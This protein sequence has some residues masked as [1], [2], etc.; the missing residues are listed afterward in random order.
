MNEAFPRFR[1]VNRAV[2]DDV[3]GT[4]F[5]VGDML[6]DAPGEQIYKLSSTYVKETWVPPFSGVPANMVAFGGRLYVAGNLT[7]ATAEFFNFGYVD[8]ATNTLQIL[9][10][11]LGNNS[12]IDQLSLSGGKII[13]TQWTVAGNQVSVGT[14]DASG[15][16]FTQFGT[17]NAQFSPWILGADIYW[18]SAGSWDAFSGLYNYTINKSQ[19]ASRL[20]QVE[21]SF[22]ADSINDIKMDAESFYIAGP[23]IDVGGSQRNN[24]AVVSRSGGFVH[25]LNIVEGGPAQK[26]F[27][28]ADEVLIAGDFTGVQG[29]AVTNFAL[30]NRLDLSLNPARMDLAGYQTSGGYY[31]YGS[32]LELAQSILIPSFSIS[33]GTKSAPGMFA[34]N[35]TTNSMEWSQTEVPYNISSNRSSMQ[36]DNGSLY[37]FNTANELVSL[38]PSG[39]RTTTNFNINSGVYSFFI[40]DQKLFIAGGFTSVLGQPVQGWAAIDLLT[41]QLI[42][43][44][45]PNL[46]D[47]Y[48]AVFIEQGGDLYLTSHYYYAND[49]N[50]AIY[51]WYNNDWLLLSLSTASVSSLSR[52]HFHDNKVVLFGQAVEN[53]IV[54]QNLLLYN[55]ANKSLSKEIT[56]SSK[57]YYVPDVSRQASF[58][59]TSPTTSGYKYYVYDPVNEIINDLFAGTILTNYYSRSAYL[60]SVLYLEGS[61]SAMCLSKIE[62]GTRTDLLPTGGTNTCD[63][64][65][66]TDSGVFI[67]SNY[68]AV[69]DGQSLISNISFYNHQTQQLTTNILP[70]GAYSFLFA[71]K[72]YLV[73]KMND[74]TATV[75]RIS[76]ANLQYD[77]LPANRFD[78]SFSLFEAN[79]VYTHSCWGASA[80]MAYKIFDIGSVQVLETPLNIRTNGSL[81]QFT[82]GTKKYYFGDIFQV[83]G[84][85][86]RAHF[87]VYDSVTGIVE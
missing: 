11:S 47:I 39:T 42:S 54:Y 86:R 1:W 29:Q 73:V 60:N 48:N 27:L 75:M 17:V 20:D 6:G 80:D 5:V 50:F 45:A 7:S 87:L 32:I 36:V 72:D 63:V 12:W 34:V 65:S 10:S 2:Q 71:T 22:K 44:P 82:L 19:I 67:D 74:L 79:Q 76:K 69:L 9:T 57:D 59:G 14:P 3:T 16:V 49:K 37:Y 62:N 25:P 56:S 53:Q 58:M 81:Q 70:A 33:K 38:S 78:C 52:V 24:F 15:L 13:I 46:L 55:P 68:I 66:S 23:I 51:K 40:R 84:K 43:L 30:L 64:I 83:Q 8:L 4:V 26:I 31:Y 18:L 85:Y 41:N 77:V 61:T 28:K 21:L 35:T